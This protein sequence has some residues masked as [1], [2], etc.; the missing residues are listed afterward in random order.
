MRKP[1]ETHDRVCAC[2]A[3]HRSHCQLSS[4]SPYDIFILLLSGE[5]LTVIPANKVK[6]SRIARLT[7]C[8]RWHLAVL[9][10]HW[11]SL[12]ANSGASW[13]YHFIPR[14]SASLDSKGRVFQILD[15]LSKMAERMQQRHKA[16][17][18][19]TACPTEM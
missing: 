10:P 3:W 9:S 5:R 1:V 18:G 7:E 17:L 14:F 8:K 16:G 6:W 2:I 13:E 19:L 4:P 12:S 11:E 15:L